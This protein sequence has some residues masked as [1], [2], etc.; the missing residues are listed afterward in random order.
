MPPP[1]PQ[2]CV[3]YPV[4]GHFPPSR[5]KAPVFPPPPNIGRRPLPEGY[6]NVA[7][8]PDDERVQWIRTRLISKLAGLTAITVDKEFLL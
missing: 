6:R 5:Y 2:T 8:L 7:V 1:D 4:R 3:H